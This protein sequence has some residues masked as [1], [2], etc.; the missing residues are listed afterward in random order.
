MALFANERQGFKPVYE[1]SFGER[2]KD[3][4]EPRIISPIPEEPSSRTFGERFEDLFFPGYRESK[5]REEKE[6]DKSLFKEE[7]VEPSPIKVPEVTPPPKPEEKP[8][9][10]ARNPNISKFTI[11]DTVKDAITSAAKKYGIP[12]DLLFDIALQESSFDPNKKNPN[13]PPGLNPL[14]LFQFTDET[15]ER[16]KVYNRMKGSSL[17]LPNYDRFDPHTNALAAA[18]LIKFGQL[19]RWDASRD[20]WGPYY[21]DEELEPYYR[22]RLSRR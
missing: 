6:V 19:G 17:D 18:Y 8:V 2:L 7:K 11:T 21:S 20:V 12:H 22:Q 15:W 9:Q 5:R 3:L 10:L 13:A 16:V 14:G 4:F 1:R